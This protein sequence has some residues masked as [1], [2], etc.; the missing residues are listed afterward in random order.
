ML[1]INKTCTLMVLLLAI[2]ACAGGFRNA[3]GL[4]RIPPDEFKVV[5]N[6][7]LT[8]PPE[9]ILRPPVPGAKRPQE[10]DVQQQAKSILFESSSKNE[11]SDESKSE[12]IFLKKADA[13]TADPDIRNLLTQEEVDSAK[14][15]KK[16]GFFD[17]MMSFAS[18]NPDKDTVVNAAKEKERIETNKKEDK[19]VNTGDVPEVQPSSGGLLNNVFGF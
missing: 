7:P 14:V 18:K 15:E 2:T 4:S 6:A 17:K 5:S 10:V 1:K 13:Q 8:V 9:F 3:A 11:N 19:P 16:K 12:S